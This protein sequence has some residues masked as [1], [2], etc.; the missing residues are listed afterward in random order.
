MAVQP[1]AGDAAG[2]RDAISPPPPEGDGHLIGKLRALGIDAPT[3]KRVLVVD[4]E[5][6]NLFVL[7]ALLEDEWDLLLAGSGAEALAM[8]ETHGPVDLV[9]SDQRMPGMTGVELLE[10]VA[11]RHPETM[12]MVLTAYADVQ[13]IVDAVNLGSVYRFLLKPWDPWEMRAAVSQ[14]LA[15]KAHSE[16]LR[17]VVETLAERHGQLV[18]TLDDL[19]RAQTQLVAADRLTTLGRLT[20]G[21]THEIRN[22]LAVTQVLLETIESETADPAVLGPARDALI[23]LKSMLQLMRHITAFSKR[24]AMDVSRSETFT[25]RF[26]SETLALFRLESAGRDQE[27]RVRLDPGADALYVDSRGLG[28]ALLALL[29]N[30]AQAS[31][32]GQP[33]EV[34]ATVAQ[35]GLL[36]IS[37]V[38]SGCG[39]SEAVLRRA[40]EPFFSASEPASLGLGLEITRVIAEAHGGRLEL[41]SVLGSG[42]TARLLVRRS[43]EI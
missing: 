9:I 10:A 5:P 27:V 40:P 14:S 37:V 26:I 18:R 12:R 29:R 33:I 22:Q 42:T 24:Q 17:L 21:V 38:D 41:A 4:D 19:R 15:R 30:A 8:I 3:C 1:R 2:P 13:P 16:A 28:Q 11:A 6:D 36:S 20:S 34:Q 43:E 31:A 23:A 25:A 35:G 39:M 32:P 7:E